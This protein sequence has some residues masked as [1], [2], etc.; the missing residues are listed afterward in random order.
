MSDAPQKSPLTLF[1]W[2]IWF[3]ILSGLFVLQFLLGGG[4]EAAGNPSL[5]VAFQVGALVLAAVSLFVRF[6]VIPRIENMAKKL[7]VMIIGLAIAE[8]IGIIGIVIIPVEQATVRLFLLSLSIICIV[9]SA[10]VY[11]LHRKGSSPFRDGSA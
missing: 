6:R 11:V 10:P 4:P 3:S 7:P 9:L 2:V 1:F 5:L 8:A